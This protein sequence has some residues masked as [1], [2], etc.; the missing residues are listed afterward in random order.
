MEKT[1][2]AQKSFLL[3]GSYRNYHKL[4]NLADHIAKINKIEKRKARMKNVSERE[5]MGIFV[6]CN[7]TNAKDIL[8][9]V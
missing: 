9:G 4:D 6:G 5:W 2:S 8:L 3:V 1:M 7:I